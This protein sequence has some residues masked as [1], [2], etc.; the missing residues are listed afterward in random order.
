MKFTF[1]TTKA[2]GPYRSFHPDH[3]DI[4]LKKKCC[5]LITDKNPHRIH[6]MV[7]KDGNKFKDDNHNCSW[8]WITLMETFDS[9]ADAKIFMN[10]KIADSELSKCLHLE[11]D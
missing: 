6:L 9:I 5:G 7:V 8:K 4:K 10:E 1:K 11:E 2:T 3:H